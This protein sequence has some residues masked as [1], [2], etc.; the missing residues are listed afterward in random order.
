MKTLTSSI[1]AAL[2]LATVSLTG[3]SLLPQRTILFGAWTEGFFDAQTRTLHPETLTAFETTIGKHVSLAHYY[4][5]W[6]YLSDPVLIQQFD[7]LRSHNWVPVL[8]VNPYYFSACPASDKPLYR[9]IADGQCDA[10]LHKAGKNLHGTHGP[11]YLLFAWEMNNDSQSWSLAKTN[12]TPQDYVDAWKHMHTIFAE[13]GAKNIIWVFCP[14][15]Y[16]DTSVDY[17]KLYPGDSYVD[18]TGV[19][20]YNW[21]TTQSWS[22]WVDFA[23]IFTKSYQK[24]TSIAPNKP[25][26]LAE[27]NSTDQGGNKADWYTNALTKE[28]PN[29]FPQIKAIVI[30]NEDR[31]SQENVNWKVDATQES[32]AAFKTAI[33]TKT[34]K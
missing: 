2:M 12:S 3:H 30:Y 34:Y 20:G 33:Q 9:A 7:T 13:E 17:A 26:M 15:I 21:G 8:N 24:L 25:V 22:S 28:I 16:T 6:E 31:T 5:G 19:D 14:N 23:G 4:L 10:F 1:M 18:W 29:N 32:L 11:F 27:F